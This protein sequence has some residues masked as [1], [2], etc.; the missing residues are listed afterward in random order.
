MTLSIK[1]T[2][3]TEIV[4]PPTSAENDHFTLSWLICRVRGIPKMSLIAESGISPASIAGWDLGKRLPSQRMME[5]IL[6]GTNITVDEA[7]E[8]Q[9][10]I[11]PNLQTKKRRI[12]AKE[13]LRSGYL[14]K[15]KL[16]TEPRTKEEIVSTGGQEF[17]EREGNVGKSIPHDDW[18]TL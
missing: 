8:R 14:T 4:G 6:T 5:K 12:P 1:K 11:Y 9:K 16:R 2:R 10:R 13:Y 17:A 3:E 7:M 15:E 18:E